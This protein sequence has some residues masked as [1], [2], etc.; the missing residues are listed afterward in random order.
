M[1][2]ERVKEGQSRHRNIH[3][4]AEYDEDNSIVNTTTATGDDDVDVDRDGD[5]DGE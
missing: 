1:T 3:T 2:A 4:V 5:G